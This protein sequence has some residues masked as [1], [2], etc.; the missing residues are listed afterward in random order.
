ME[1]RSLVV[2]YT[3][4]GNTKK[5]ALK[6]KTIMHATCEALVDK[7]SYK[8]AIG[9]IKGGY[10]SV[11]KKNG[12]IEPVKYNPAD[13]DEVIVLSPVWAGTIT[14]AVRTYLKEFGKTIKSVS[15]ITVAASSDESA[16]VKEINEL[17]FSLDK[18]M[19]VKDEEVKSGSYESKLNKFLK[20]Y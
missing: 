7:D 18:T 11:K 8:G 14:P 2:Y 15:L 9:F 3:R 10:K 4:T 17:G 19:S 12:V 5:I 16:A 6:L 1:K 13:F 20:I